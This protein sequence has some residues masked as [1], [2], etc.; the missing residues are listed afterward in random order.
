MQCWFCLWMLI[1]T[2]R[3]AVNNDD[4]QNSSRKNSS[5]RKW[6]SI[7]NSGNRLITMDDKAT[8]KQNQQT[9]SNIKSG[10]RFMT[11]DKIATA[12]TAV[13]KSGIQSTK[14]G[15]TLMTIASKWSFWHW[16]SA[17][18]RECCGTSPASTLCDLVR[19]K[20]WWRNGAI[21]SGKLDYSQGASKH[22]DQYS[23]N[24]SQHGQGVN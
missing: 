24:G 8:G 20:W 18:E 22:V 1:K 9:G 5:K 11:I 10:N 2:L 13:A 17:N 14:V 4:R 7:N 6:K 15:N 23:M 16:V 12:T 3:T 21:I 19:P